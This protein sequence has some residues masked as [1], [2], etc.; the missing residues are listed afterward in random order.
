MTDISIMEFRQIEK[1]DLGIS[2]AVGSVRCETV[3]L[4]QS[5]SKIRDLISR[6]R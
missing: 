4:N 1:A 6:I 3:Q 5:S 2:N